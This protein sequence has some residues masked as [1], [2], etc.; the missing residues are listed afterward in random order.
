MSRRPN[1]APA[2]PWTSVPPGVAATLLARS[3][4]AALLGLTGLVALAACSTTPHAVAA[5]G[6]TASAVASAVA[7]PS[8]AGSASAVCQQINAVV[9]T[10]LTAFGTDVGTLAGHVSSKN[11]AAA[12]K[13]K[14]SALGRLTT[15]AGKIRSTGQAAPTVKVTSAA[16]ATAGNLEQ[17]AAD[18]ALLA[19]VK[20]AADVPPVIQ[21]VTSATDP[22]INACA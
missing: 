5:T 18:P 6:P 3:V 2:R 11:T 10:D 17:L 12:D 19:N 14:A 22:L 4:A 1:D 9:A 21:R 8:P 15:L 20:A 7:T 13:A 16:Q